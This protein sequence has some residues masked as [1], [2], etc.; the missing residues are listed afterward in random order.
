MLEHKISELEELQLS[1]L[2]TNV[3]SFV[4]QFSIT[5]LDQVFSYIDMK[6]ENLFPAHIKAMAKS[7]FAALLA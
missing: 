3:Q 7:K 2:V 4:D 6:D 5:S 1:T